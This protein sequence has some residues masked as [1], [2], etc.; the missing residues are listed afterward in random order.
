M[1]NI[2][3]ERLLKEAWNSHYDKEYES[4][5]G[6]YKE[7]GYTVR[8]N[9]K[10]GEHRVEKKDNSYEK[11]QAFAGTPFADLFGF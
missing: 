3:A 8:R 10:T 5:L 1:R 4:L 9:E 7:Q 2:D 6:M 11:M